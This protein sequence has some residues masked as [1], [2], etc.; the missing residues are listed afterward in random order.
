MNI[1]Q[2]CFSLLITASV[3]LSVT[4]DVAAD[5]NEEENQGG[6][7]RSAVGA[8]NKYRKAADITDIADGVKPRR[9]IAAIRNGV[10]GVRKG[11]KAGTPDLPGLLGD[12]ASDLADK[13]TLPTLARFCR[14]PVSGPGVL[15]LAVRGARAAC[16]ILGMVGS[17]HFVGKPIEEWA[18]SHQNEAIR[19]WLRQHQKSSQSSLSPGGAGS[20]QP[21]TQ[22]D[23]ELSDEA[24]PYE[25][26][27]ETPALEDPIL[28]SRHYGECGPMTPDEK[29]Q[30]EQTYGENFVIAYEGVRL[31]RSRLEDPSISGN[32]QEATRIKEIVAQQQE[33]V[34]DYLTSYRSSHGCPT[35]EVCGA[36]IEE[37][38][39]D[40]INNWIEEGRNGG[41][42]HW[43]NVSDRFYKRCI[44]SIENGHPL[45]N[46]NTVKLCKERYRE[47]AFSTLTYL[48]SFDENLQKN[49]NCRFRPDLTI[50]YSLIDD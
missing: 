44:L 48:D 49:N 46:Y 16:P 24:T 32:L 30:I 21:G 47:D 40:A 22:Q 8:V 9:G 3:G 25:G 50:R 19:Q 5:E 18:R 33:A 41:Y 35:S 11:I 31:Y 13:A 28:E 14:V 36:D 37:I 27:T 4:L 43:M 39:Q 10:G 20:E 26:P 17:D 1:V 2:I 12:T 38:R 23:E 7:A 42:L 34:A 29:A 15:G 45:T 6:N